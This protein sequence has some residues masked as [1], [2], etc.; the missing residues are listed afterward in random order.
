M[1]GGPKLG[2]GRV[3]G[4]A[5]GT[6]SVVQRTTFRPGEVA[7]LETIAA[8]WGVPLATVIWAIV[9]ERLAQWRRR[10]PEL[11]PAGL[12]IAAAVTVLRQREGGGESG[13]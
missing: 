7:D 1:G 11:G 13:P 3:R 2:S 6:R 8:G 12:A 10:A 5:P 9:H 4:P